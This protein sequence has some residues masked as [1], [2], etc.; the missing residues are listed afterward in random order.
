MNK[1]QLPA[2]GKH[3]LLYGTAMGMLFVVLKW[4]EIRYL[5]I[6]HAMDVY[7][8]SIAVLFTL[9]G[10]W[11][12]VQ[13]MQPKTVT[14]VVEKEVYVPVAVPPAKLPGGFVI[15]ERVLEQ[16]GISNR[17]LEVLQHMASGLSNQEI[18]GKLYVSVNT[19]K[20]HSSNLFLKLDVKRRTQAADKA[21]K[22][23]LIP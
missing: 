12:A 3:T 18:A 9:L 11:V 19:V 20:T 4:L 16:T 1:L 23:G 13:V 10:I 15:N 17:E 2:V 22:L 5:V 21:R 7:S 14:V 6:D 8:G